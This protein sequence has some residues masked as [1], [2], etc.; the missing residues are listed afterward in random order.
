MGGASGLSRLLQILIGVVLAV[1]ASVLVYLILVEQPAQ[2]TSTPPL[3]A[4]SQQPLVDEAGIVAVSPQPL[5]A[6]DQLTAAA[7]PIPL[8]QAVAATPLPTQSFTLD[9]NP[10][11][12][13]AANPQRVGWASRD[14]ADVTSV[15]FPDYNVYAGSYQATT[16]IGAISFDLGALGDYGP[17]LS[18]ELLLVG[19]TAERQTVDSGAWALEILAE[20]RDFWLRPEYALLA[21]APVETILADLGPTD[22]GVDQPVRIALSADV[23][24]MLNGLRY[25]K[26]SLTVRLRGPDADGSLFGFDGG[27]G[28]GS[29]GNPPRLLLVAG[30][31]EPT[32]T[33]FLVTATS[34]PAGVLTAAALLVEATANAATVGTPTPTP[35]NLIVVA[36]NAV[37]HQEFWN[38]AQG[39][40]LPVVI[41]TEVPANLSTAV[42]NL[43]IATAQAMTT[44][45]ATPLPERYVTAT[46][47]PT[48]ELIIATTTPE[49][50]MTLAA[51]LVQATAAAESQGTPTPLPIPHRIITPTPRFI[52]VTATP[53]PANVATAQVLA[54]QATVQFLLTGT[55]TPTPVNQVTVTPL[56]L[57]IPVSFFTPTPTVIP[58]LR[59]PD[60][61]PAQLRG[62]ILF[63]SDRS[64]AQELYA[65]DP[66][67]RLVYS[68][69]QQWPYA[70]AQED[71]GLAPDSKRRA[72]VSPDDA[73]ILQIQ[74]Y[75]YE[76]GDT[77]QVTTF[78]G[79]SYDPAWSPLGDQIV[80]VTTDP[81][82]DE[83]YTV[84]ADGSQSVRLTQ[85]VW[86]WDKH[87][88]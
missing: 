52:I 78:R 66:N 6:V 72:L 12:E 26:R 1:G 64:G 43:K 77:K 82:N 85:N 71:L 84:T 37:I 2:Q 42:A 14:A 23:I 88:S 65:L 57:L 4:T 83:L 69:T 60:A 39:T 62:L 5:L 38:D 55:A 86:E 8:V 32:P 30:P 29:H 87:P 48:P 27:T 13:L 46:Q 70:L 33:P 40:P 35:F 22:L 18:G 7:T 61:I 50:V 9:G 81:G 79:T 47:T 31:V 53:R 24:Q 21:E 3:L 25:Q 80:F 51:G 73:R 54:A 44:G 68:V 34:T 45:T 41:A 58:T 28:G 49:N 75:S 74:V 67:S 15:S 17:L 10:L 63:F 56:S 36:P 59:S 19:L 11:V 16:Y 20:D 76:Y